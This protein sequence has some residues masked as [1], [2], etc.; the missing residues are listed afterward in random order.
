MVLHWLRTF[1]SSYQSV[2]PLSLFTSLS[3]SPQN[4]FYVFL[5]FFLFLLFFFCC[6]CTFQPVVRS[7]LMEMNHLRAHRHGESAT[8]QLVSRQQYA[9]THSVA[10]Y[11]LNHYGLF[12]FYFIYFFLTSSLRLKCPPVVRPASCLWAGTMERHVPSEHP[13]SCDGGFSRG[14]LCP[15]SKPCISRQTRGPSLLTGDFNRAI[16]NL[17]GAESSLTTFSDSAVQGESGVG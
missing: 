16:H 7:L 17:C 4:T 8:D 12:Q 2:P 5:F 11:P 13:H 6:A 10:H 1:S 15:P 9:S 14:L 3:L